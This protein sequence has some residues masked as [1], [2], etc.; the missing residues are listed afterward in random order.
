M[1]AGPNIDAPSAD[2]TWIPGCWVWHQARY[3]W[4]PGNWVAMQPDWVWVPAYYVWTPRGYVFVD[5]YWD[6]SVAR[7]GVLFAP[8]YFD[9]GVYSQRGFSYSPA[10]VINPAVFANHLFLRPGYN[11][12]YF[13]D[14]YAANYYDAGFYPRFSFH[15]HNGYDPIYAHDRWQH[16]R[17]REWEHRQ[18]ADFRNLRD[19]E[20]SRPPRTWAAQRELETSRVKSKDKSFVLAAS[21]AQLAKSKDSP[22]RFQPL[23]KNERQKLAQ[24]GREVQKFRA[25]R[26]SGKLKRRVRQPQI[27]LS[28]PSRLG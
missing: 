22:L 11:H 4:R 23:D 19:H 13:G 2:Q 26:Q 15:N 10:T 16:R 21:L 9:A 17:D 27:F 28:N 5:G 18:E 1:E 25:E 6:Y 20:D 3:A 12:Y 14:Y 7:R 24:R 8:V